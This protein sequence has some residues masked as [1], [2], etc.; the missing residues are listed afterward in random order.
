M[1]K[2]SNSWPCSGGAG[3]QGSSGHQPPTAG[4]WPL[5]GRP[6]SPCRSQSACLVGGA[7]PVHRD[8]HAAVLVV[9]VSQRQ[10]RA[11]WALRPRCR[12]AG[13]RCRPAAGRYAASHPTVAVAGWG[14]ARAAV[15]ALMPCTGAAACRTR[16]E[17]GQGKASPH[18]WYR[19]CQARLR[20]H[21]ALPSKE[22]GL[23]AVK[24][25]RAALTLPGTSKG[26]HLLH[27]GE[28]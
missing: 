13:R 18:D 11:Q 15:G 2:A 10:A 20:A 19:C 6:C 1:L 14:H 8:R 16:P 12:G 28:A 27:R 25:H 7:I 9:L 24:V 26:A 17:V 23:A 4:R 22:V 5:S 3:L 21:N